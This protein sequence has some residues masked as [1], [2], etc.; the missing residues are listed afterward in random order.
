MPVV[1]SLPTDSSATFRS[2]VDRADRLVAHNVR[3]EFSALTAAPTAPKQWWGS[4]LGLHPDGLEVFAPSGQAFRFSAWSIDRVPRPWIVRAR[5][6][7]GS[8]GDLPVRMTARR[9]SGLR[10]NGRS[11]RFRGPVQALKRFDESGGQW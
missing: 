11:A 9:W 4:V 7:S 3:A 10:D 1:Q 8:A 5:H 6:L 2:A